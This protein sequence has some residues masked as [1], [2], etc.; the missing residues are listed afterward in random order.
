MSTSCD[1]RLMKTR[2]LIFKKSYGGD[3]ISAAS[4][5][6]V[7]AY[8]SSVSGLSLVVPHLTQFRSFRRRTWQDD[9]TAHHLTDTDKNRQYRKSAQ[10]SNLIKQLITHNKKATMVLSPLATLGRERRWAY[11]TAP[12]PPTQS[13]CF[14]K[15]T[16]LD[17]R[18]HT[19]MR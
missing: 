10:L 19:C 8:V 14:H 3:D 11:Y 15:Y 6:A 9:R 2:F 16:L 4:A 18:I 12:E 13:T 7:P 17:C 5:R 1:C